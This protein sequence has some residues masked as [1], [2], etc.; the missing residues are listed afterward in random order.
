MTN[1]IKNNLIHLLETVKADWVIYRGFSR[2]DI[3]KM[4]KFV[5]KKK[6]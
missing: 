3:D 1:N 2:E 6:E 5:E 4:I